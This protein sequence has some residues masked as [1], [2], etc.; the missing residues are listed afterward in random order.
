MPLY[1]ALMRPGVLHPGLRAKICGHE[2]VGV[3]PEEDQKMLKGLKH[4]SYEDRLREL[5]LQSLEKRR[6]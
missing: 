2:P 4:L 3:R 1:S 6:L 5:R